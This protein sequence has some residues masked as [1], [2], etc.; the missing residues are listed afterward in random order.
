MFKKISLREKIKKIDKELET[1]FKKDPYYAY[2]FL[3][4]M[5]FILVVAITIIVPIIIDNF[6]F[7]LQSYEDWLGFS[8]SYMGSIIGGLLSGAVT[9]LI[10][11]ATHKKTDEAI[12]LTR[13]SL[14]QTKK[15]YEEEKR[16]N[17]IPYIN[18]E[19]VKCSNSEL[20]YAVTIYG[21]TQSTI[22]DAVS[23][24]KFS[25]IGHGNC[26]S[27]KFKKFIIDEIIVQEED[28]EIFHI[29][30]SIKKGGINLEL[31]EQALMNIELKM[32]PSWTDH[33]AIAKILLEFQDIIGNVYYQEITLSTY[34]RLIFVSQVLPPKQQKKNKQL[35]I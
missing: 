33:T 25:N 34:H 32:G 2:F 9:F 16:L 11:I 8:G 13:E 3:G 35:D 31:N 26:F 4:G 6:I 10:L 24:F 20:Q 30:D 28:I 22:I 27:L 19:T 12:K 21:D 23:L 17:V 29:N 18:A 15:Q 1:E 7:P 5:V 14:S